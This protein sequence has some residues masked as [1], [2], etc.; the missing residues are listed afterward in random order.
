MGVTNQQ[1]TSICTSTRLSAVMA[2]M[3][4]PP[5]QSSPPTDR[6]IIRSCSNTAQCPALM[7][8]HSVSFHI[9]H[10]SCGSVTKSLRISWL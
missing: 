10:I 1:P 6:Q 2:P 4:A 3:Q 5:S 8:P 7:S 9:P